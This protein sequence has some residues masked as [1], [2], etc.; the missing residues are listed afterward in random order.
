M[1]RSTPPPGVTPLRL[2]R[3]LELTR[4]KAELDSPA[5]ELESPSDDRP[6]PGELDPPPGELDPPPG[7]SDSPPNDRPAPGELD[8][9]SNHVEDRPNLTAE[10]DLT[11]TGAIQCWVE[12]ARFSTTHYCGCAV[13]D[14]TRGEVRLRVPTGSA[15]PRDAAGYIFCIQKYLGQNWLRWFGEDTRQKIDDLA[16]EFSWIG[17]AGDMAVRAILDAWYAEATHVLNDYVYP[18]LANAMSNSSDAEAYIVSRDDTAFEI[19][20]EW[21]DLE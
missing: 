6:A 9:P 3:T 11:L 18:V 5:G 8:P 7:E 2:F 15:D 10:V 16:S 20:I 17:V 13:V 12:L 19:K 14:K 1:L 4:L 21:D